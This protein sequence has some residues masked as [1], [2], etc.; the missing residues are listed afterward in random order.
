MYGW[1]KKND[2]YARHMRQYE[3][4]WARRVENDYMEENCLKYDFDPDEDQFPEEKRKK[5]KP[6]GFENIISRELNEMNKLIN[7]RTKVTHKKKINIRML[8]DGPRPTVGVYY[9]HYVTKWGDEAGGKEQ[10]TKEKAEIREV[11]TTTR[12]LREN[13]NYTKRFTEAREFLEVVDK[14][15]DREKKTR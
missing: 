13:N 4:L 11:K 5:R 12:K 14:L 10:T 9:P 3:L 1:F 7:N 6:N 15:K 8:K 2:S